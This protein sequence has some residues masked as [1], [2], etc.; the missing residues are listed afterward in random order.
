MLV[1]KK[2]AE[3][4]L[5]MPVLAVGSQAFIGK[6][7]ANQMYKVAEN[8]E[9]QELKFGHQLAEECPEDLAKVYLAFLQK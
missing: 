5:K 7:V 8:V 6:E 3:V 4:K 2:A 9:Y 1:N